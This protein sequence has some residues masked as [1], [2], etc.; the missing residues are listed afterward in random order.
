[1]KFSKSTDKLV[2]VIIVTKDRGN[3]LIECIDSFINNSYKPLEIIVVDNAS[4]VPVEKMLK[5]KYKNIIL[6]RNDENKGAAEGRNIGIS[7]AK[8]KYLLFSDDDAV[9]SVNMVSELVNV[10][11]KYENVG[12]VQPLI[13]D[14]HN[15]KLFQ[16]AGHDIDLLTGRIK[17]FGINIWGKSEITWKIILSES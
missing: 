12:I 15:K 7:A 1:M 13:Y 4:N 14:K 6:V 5:I 10:F 2:S 3:Q 11:K 8:G 16:G 9:A 17:P